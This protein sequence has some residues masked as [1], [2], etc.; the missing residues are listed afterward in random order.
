MRGP[1]PTPVS[2]TERQR[3]VLE[4]VTRRQTS[5]QQLVRRA[6]IILLAATG[7]NNDQIA[8][9][10]DLDRG[11]VRTWRARWLSSA[12]RLD[13]AEAAGEPERVWRDLVDELLQDAPRAGAPDTFS[14]EQVVQIVAL[15]CEV[16]PAA[17]RPT[18]HW[19]PQELALEA[20]KRGIVAAISPRTVGRFLQS[21]RAEAPSE[22]LLAQSQAGRSRRL[23]QT[24]GDG[25]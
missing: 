21:G 15:A 17:E 5:P 14:A 7:G 19:I 16:P 11:T 25:V 24:G 12:S 4:H 13:V 6:H 22:S 20:V 9:H 3:A 23:R 1:K 8:R 18:S 10:R 2:L